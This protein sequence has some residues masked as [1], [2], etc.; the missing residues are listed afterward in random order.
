M[1]NSPAQ[2]SQ[3][4]YMIRHPLTTP[5]ATFVAT[6]KYPREV[7]LQETPP[8]KKYHRVHIVRSFKNQRSFLSIRQMVLKHPIG[9]HLGASY[10]HTNGRSRAGMLRPV[11]QSHRT[12]AS[13]T[14][15]EGSAF[16]KTAN[17]LGIYRSA[18]FQSLKLNSKLLT[19]VGNCIWVT[20]GNP[21]VIL[22][23]ATTLHTTIFRSVNRS[24]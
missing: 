23:R 18:L 15:V 20:M 16:D 5:K 19:E 8:K 13:N 7:L 1:T 11:V 4:F 24:V 10:W 6:L 12:D 14:T 9:W 21:I 22:T 3:P 2:R 17:A